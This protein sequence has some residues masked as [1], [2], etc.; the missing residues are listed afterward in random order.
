MKVMILAHEAPE[1]FAQRESKQTSGAYLGAW[2][3]YGASLREAGA[4]LSG[5]A[6]EAPSAA[7]VVS[8]RNGVRKVED[9][10]FPD[11]KEQLVGFA[12]IEAAD[13]A[14]AADWAAKC[15]AAKNGFVDVRVVP[16]YASG[17]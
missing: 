6:L 16:D 17:E 3:A 15:P 12:V 10:P 14:A 1:D 4:Y 8:V 13:L 9:G 7:T 2:R 11:S 5:A